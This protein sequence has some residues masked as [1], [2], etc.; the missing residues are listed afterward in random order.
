MKALIKTSPRQGA[1]IGEVKNPEL[2][3]NEILIRPEFAAVC[4]TDI[5]LYNWDSSGQS[6]VKKFNVGFPFIFGHEVSGTVEK[7]G[8]SVTRVQPG[9]KVTFETHIPCMKCYACDIGNFHNCMDMGL[10]GLTYNGAFAEYATAPE[11]VVFKIPDGVSMKA[12]SL[13][14]PAAV[15]MHGV[16]EAHIST[17]DTV[18][19][20][21]CGPIGLI[22]VQL[23]FASGA[24]R[25]ISL[26]INEYR[27]KKAGQLGA[28]TINPKTA[29]VRKTVAEI[30]RDAGGVDVAIELTGSAAVYEYLFDLIRLEGRLVSIGHPG[31]KV[32][33]DVT[34][35]INLKGLSWK[36]I[37]GR[38][39]WKSW[40]QLMR[41]LQNGKV[42]IESVITHEFPLKDYEKA[43]T[44]QGDVG[45]IVFNEFSL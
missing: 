12:A 18:L 13:F 15:A 23:A 17:G 1:V 4:G 6:F 5:H 11:H 35:N 39:I 19:I 40:W 34:T 42:D 36:G 30:C 8:S 38:K 3:R 43:F 27:L 22:A 32:E 33:F 14:E 24:S 41:M 7:I 29:D 10:Y 45:K 9:D 20:C 28:I 21:G 31:G 16:D 37:F 44:I 26:D 25:V 2:N